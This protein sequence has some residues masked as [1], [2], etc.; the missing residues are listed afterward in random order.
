MS[1]S[2]EVLAVVLLL[3]IVSR[4]ARA[5]EP[6]TLKQLLKQER[7]ES[8]RRRSES[9]AAVQYLMMFHAGPKLTT[10]YK[11]KDDLWQ[12]QVDTRILVIS[13]FS[14]DGKMAIRY[15]V[16]DTG[17]AHSVRDVYD[18]ARQAEHDRPLGQDELTKLKE[19]LPDVPKSDA[20]PPI[21]RAVC[22]SFEGKDGWRTETFD[23]EKLPNEVESLMKI[24]GERFETRDRHKLQNK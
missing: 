24:V 10:K 6:L 15:T 9:R 16:S 19:L 21:N 7:D 18:W 14:L 4:T 8:D 12:V 3:A 2:A 23:A 11:G 22:V 13:R 20:D 1:R 17:R 5:E